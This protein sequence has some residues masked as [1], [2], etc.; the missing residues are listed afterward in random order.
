MRLWLFMDYG[1]FDKL[2]YFFVFT[3]L[4]IVYVLWDYR[5]ECMR[6]CFVKGLECG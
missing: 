3:G 2:R 6:E 1:I 4:I 5:E